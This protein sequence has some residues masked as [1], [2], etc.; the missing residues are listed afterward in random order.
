MGYMDKMH[1]EKIGEAYLGM[2]ME[3]V[4]VQR[5]KRYLLWLFLTITV[6][7]FLFSNFQH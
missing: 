3:M 7:N 1:K 5:Y 2:K 4:S 6:F